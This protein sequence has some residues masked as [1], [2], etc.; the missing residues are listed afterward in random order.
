MAPGLGEF[1][2]IAQFYRPLA[3]GFDGALGLTDDAGLL[4]VPP[5]RELVVTTDAM[6]AGIHYL[7]GEDPARLAKKLLRVNL[8]DLAAMG[9]E[10]LAYT[11]ITALPP[12]LDSDW[13][14]RLAAGLAD[15]QQRY[16][17]ALLGGDSVSTRGPEV[18]SI[19]A[20]GTVEAGQALRRSGARPGDTI[21]VSG[22]VGDGVLGLEAARGVLGD[23]APEQAAALAA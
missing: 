7:A 12:E 3:R 18:L 6:V 17:I 8:S 19:T 15:D 16:G 20:L 2:R 14:A 9:A 5:G 4:T 13:V 22:T 11:L 1:E 10:P 21:F 23:I